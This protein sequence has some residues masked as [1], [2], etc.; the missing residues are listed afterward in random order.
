MGAQ[1]AKGNGG[2]M[3]VIMQLGVGHAVIQSHIVVR[4]SSA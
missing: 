4:Y 2:V 1:S 3:K